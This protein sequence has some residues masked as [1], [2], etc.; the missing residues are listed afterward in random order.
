MIC[1]ICG[2]GLVAGVHVLVRSLWP[3]SQVTGWVLFGG[4]IFLAL[5][6]LRKKLVVLP[7]GRT[8]TWLRLHGYIGL[9]TSLL[10]AVHAF[11]LPTL[12]WRLPDGILERTI[13]V[14]FVVVAG[15]GM[16]GLVIARWVPMR[17]AHRGEELI[18][19][20]MAGFRAELRA[21]S[22][23]AVMRPGAVSA[24][25]V[26]SGYYADRLF[27]FFS[28]PS[29]VVSHL[30]QSRAPLIALRGELDELC[31]YLSDGEQQVARDLAGLIEKK[32]ELDYQYAHQL[33]LKGWLFVHAGLVGALLLLALLHGVV[34]T[35]FGGLTT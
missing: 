25:G 22:R 27:R 2:V 29:N 33:L 28:R 13:A 20:R 21:K 14:L 15:S 31:R 30:A 32:D 35:A 9:L 17:I 12:A 7:L 10:F 6:G 19:E 11:F 3:A 5:Y 34:A 24:D 23:A 26:L 16:L 18:F 1:A 8:S 4:L